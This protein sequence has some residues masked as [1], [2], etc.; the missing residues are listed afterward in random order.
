MSESIQ[1]D[2]EPELYVVKVLNAREVVISGGKAA[3]I[4]EGDMFS[5]LS[6]A[7]PIKDPKTGEVLGD[8]VVSKALV[9]VYQ[10]SEKFALAQTF[11]TKRVKVGGGVG[12]GITDIFNPPKYETRKETLVRDAS[13]DVQGDLAVEPG[14]PVRRWDG[15]PDDA[16]SANVWQ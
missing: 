8:L 11:R 7:D 2:V 10:V 12:G 5:I 14:D 16:P 6:N 9:K 15:E 4:Q 13:Y 1:P 3:G